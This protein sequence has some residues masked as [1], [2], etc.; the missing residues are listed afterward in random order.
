ML[1]LYVYRTVRGVAMRKAKIILTVLVIVLGLAVLGCGAGALLARHEYLTGNVFM[2]DGT[3]YSKDSEFIDLRG[4]QVSVSYYE[5]LREKLPDTP[6][7]WEVPFQG[8]YLDPNTQDL[9][10]TE[11]SDEDIILLDYITGLTTVNAGGCK[12]YDQLLALQQR[13]P[14]CDVRYYVTVGNKAYTQDTTSIIAFGITDEEASL[15]HYLPKLE[16]LHLVDPKASP[17]TV[18]ALRESK[19]VVSVEAEILGQTITED[20]TH[21]EFED[22][23]LTSIEELRCLAYFPELEQVFLGKC[24]FDNEALAAYREEMRDEFKLVWTVQT[25]K[26]WTRTDDLFFMPVKYRIYYFHDEDTYNLRYCEDMICID[27]GHMAIHDISFVENMP[28]LQYLVLAH[29]TVLDITPLSTCKNLKFLELDH[30]G[31]TDYTPLLGCTALEDLNLG[32]TYGDED[33]IA[34]MTWLK[35]LWWAGRG[36]TFKLKMN[37]LLPDTRKQFNGKNTVD[38][39]WR[40]LPNYYAMRDI[41]GM[42]YM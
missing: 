1:T 11:L 18:Q 42:E 8:G 23:P 36:Y 35:N 37:E 24:G 25:G 39:G 6:I 13:R 19:L 9:T 21:L 17:E 5:E 30:T 40:Q 33:I 32:K 28:N 29:T 4:Q 14:E 10:I 31:I 3:R 20:V 27:L 16:K 12:D 26:L 38:G 41:L 34:Q 7:Y 22:V 15:I 2:S